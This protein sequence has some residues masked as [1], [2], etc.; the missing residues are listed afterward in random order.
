MSMRCF[1]VVLHINEVHVHSS[2]PLN[3]TKMRNNMNLVAHLLKQEA[4]KHIHDSGNIEYCILTA[5]DVAGQ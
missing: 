4:Y 5:K 2:G 3:T 1:P